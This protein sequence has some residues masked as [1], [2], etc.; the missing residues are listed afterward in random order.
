VRQLLAL[1]PDV[2]LNTEQVLCHPWITDAAPD[3]YLGDNY[4]SRI[5]HLSLRQ[6][7]RKF[8]L[9]NDI[10]E[11]NRLRT[12]HVKNVLKNSLH[13]HTTTTKKRASFALPATID[14]SRGW[15]GGPNPVIGTA[16]SASPL[17]SSRSRQSIDSIK[18]DA[19]SSSIGSDSGTTLRRWTHFSQDTYDQK[20]NT[21]K[22]LMVSLI[23]DV[24]TFSCHISFDHVL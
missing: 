16:V 3:V 18:S 15:N 14:K 4:V 17:H 24:S 13:K 8:F 6:K 5:K 11:K 1:S 10:A 22:E 12:D 20:M 21:F 7:M 2:R 23:N 9:N 19:R